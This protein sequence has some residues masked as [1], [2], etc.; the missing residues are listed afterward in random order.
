M[1]PNA[2]ARA[3]HRPPSGH[4]EVRV[5]MVASGICHTDLRCDAEVYIDAG[6]LGRCRKIADVVPTLA[7]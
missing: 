4:E 3:G 7:S 2:D 1:G 5:R 6:S